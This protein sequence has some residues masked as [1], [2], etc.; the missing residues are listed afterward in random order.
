[1]P[2]FWL[3]TVVD[4][5][6]HFLIRA[7]VALA[8][9]DTEDQS[10]PTRPSNS[11]PG[12]SGDERNVVTFWSEYHKFC[13]R[14]DHLGVK[15]RVVNQEASATKLHAIA[16]R[17]FEESLTARVHAQALKRTVSIFLLIG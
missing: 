11:T 6:I 12:A 2:W 17:V 8:V 4:I 10:N 5:K 7:Q 3:G 9:S 1:M 15:A 13:G 16:L 14:Y